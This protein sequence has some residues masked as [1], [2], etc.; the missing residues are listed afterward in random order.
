MQ[1]AQKPSIN[2]RGHVSLIILPNDDSG[3]SLFKVNFNKDKITHVC[4]KTID[5][6]Q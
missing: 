5:Y 3:V 2:T 1:H 4:I 6:L